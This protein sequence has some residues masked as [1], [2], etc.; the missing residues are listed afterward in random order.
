[1]L[2]WARHSS[3]PACFVF[4]HGTIWCSVMVLSSIQSKIYLVFT[5][6][7]M[8]TYS[9]HS[10][11][12]LVFSHSRVS[13]NIVLW[14]LQFPGQHFTCNNIIFGLIGTLCWWHFSELYHCE[15]SSF[16]KKLISVTRNN[17]L[18]EE[19]T[20]SQRKWSPEQ[21]I[22]TCHKKLLFS[23]WNQSMMC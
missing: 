20:F 19:I 6:G 12:Y 21:N 5:N 1:M 11:Y 22:K 8:V 17:F 15:I 7:N 23:V 14:E 4:S 3:A 16:Y 2:S 18:T 13:E 10:C 9:F